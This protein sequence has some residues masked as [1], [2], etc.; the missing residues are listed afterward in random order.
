MFAPIQT[1]A[2][3]TTSVQDKDHIS[4]TSSKKSK[5]PHP[6]ANAL[7]STH[8]KSHD[9]LDLHSWPMVANR[10]QSRHA[11]KRCADTAMHGQGIQARTRAMCIHC[12]GQAVRHGDARPG[13][14]PRSRPFFCFVW[15]RSGRSRPWPV[16]PSAR[17]RPGHLSPPHA[18]ALTCGPPLNT[19]R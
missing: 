18:L 8:L 11:S 10:A 2:I 17:P 6:S 4:Q 9:T 12:A 14:S 16:R 19:E 5:Q 13:H 3:C 7:V 15:P 1:Y